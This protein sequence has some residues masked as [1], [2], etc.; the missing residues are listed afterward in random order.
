MA[1]PGPAIRYNTGHE[2]RS[3]NP[4][5]QKRPV[6]GEEEGT[7]NSHG[8]QSRRSVHLA[9][10][11]LCAGSLLVTGSASAQTR[12][13]SGKES[14]LVVKAGSQLSPAINGSLVAYVD[15]STGGC[16]VWYVDVTNGVLLQVTRGSGDEIDPAIAD[17]RLVYV[18]LADSNRNIWSVDL[19][20]GTSTQVTSGRPDPSAPAVSSRFIAW[21]DVTGDFD[22]DILVRDLALGGD[23]S[24]TAPGPQITP[25]ASGSR[26][27]YLDL[28]AN[29]AVK[30]Y[31]AETRVTSTV[32]GGPAAEPDIDGI[33]V[34][35]ARSGPSDTD[36]AV[37]DV[38]GAALSFLT[39]DGFQGNPHISGEWVSFEDFSQAMPHVGLWHWT[40]G[41]VFFPAPAASSQEMSD[42]S[43]NRLVYTD[44][45]SGDMDVY[46]FEFSLSTGGD[47]TPPVLVVPGSIITNA[48]SPSGATVIYAVTATDDTD[49]SP[50]V[51]CDVPSGSTFPV[52]T[53]TVTCT[54]T[55][56]SGNSSTKSFLVIV[57]GAPDQLQDLIALVLSF[58][59]RQ[60]IENS[61]DVKLKTAEGALDAAITGQRPTS[62]N[63]LG[64]F[65]NEVNAQAEK[66]ITASQ[67]TQLLAAAG[68]IQATLGCP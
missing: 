48:T 67:A 30:V 1:R 33:N 14:P 43:G 38:S 27:V 37:S 9:A 31:D 29:G 68:Q 8:R 45:R 57:R 22:R 3:L 53:T 2:S 56:A 23:Y 66:M 19:L 39:L 34:T 28:A 54:A 63:A 26:V 46:V 40:G 36:I 20:A 4:D 18:E 55:D 13:F 58:N 64:A 5:S 42:I 32:F 59:F 52:G 17:F 50:A 61:L 15:C 44:D 65:G 62:C 10:V 47:T 49:P 60:G 51:T 21:Q 7:M 12:T 41:E 35:Y 11:L 25:A 16:D 24:I 6:S